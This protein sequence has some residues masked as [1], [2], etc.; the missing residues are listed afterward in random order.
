MAANF[1][2]SY[3]KDSQRREHIIAKNALNTAKEK[4]KWA[5]A[6]LT[7]ASIDYAY[8]K[9]K[10][11]ALIIDYTQYLGALTTFFEAQSFYDESL[12]EYEIKKAEFL[13]NNGENLEEFL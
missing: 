4:I 9:D 10:F 7:S 6:A 5:D 3:Q 2:Y 12:F 13:Y 11:N 8:A 1:E